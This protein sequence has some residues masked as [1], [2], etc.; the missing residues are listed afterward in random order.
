MSVHFSTDELAVAVDQY[1]GDTLISDYSKGVNNDLER[2]AAG[3]A[4]DIVDNILDAM[5]KKFNI[6]YAEVIEFL[7]FIRNRAIDAAKDI[8]EFEFGF[9]FID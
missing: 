7:S 5:A 1:V 8:L 3:D 4:A 9:T 6:C 2:L